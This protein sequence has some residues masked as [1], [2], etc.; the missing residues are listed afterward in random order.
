MKK[1]VWCEEQFIF[2]IDRMRRHVNDL[3]MI[4]PFVLAIL[5][6]IIGAPIIIVLCN[7][8]IWACPILIIVPI[9]LV[10]LIFLIR[11]RI[12]INRFLSVTDVSNKV[13]LTDIQSTDLEALA[14]DE[15]FMFRCSDYMVEILYNWLYSMGVI[16]D[17][18]L[19]L[20]KVFYDNHA[21]Q[22]LAIRKADLTIPAE[23]M[24][25]FNEETFMCLRLSDMT[26]NGRSVNVKVYER[27]TKRKKRPIG[28]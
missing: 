22:Y 10:A 24:D 26:P 17:T 19:H 20:Y 18:K 13:D 4:I 6:T 5:F 1:D 28:K 2:S 25:R 8:P 21:P 9:P 12:I 23:A 7:V 27:V 3:V 15:I 11:K 16:K 14:D